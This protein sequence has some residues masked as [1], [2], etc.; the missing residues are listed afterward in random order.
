MTIRYDLESEKSFLLSLKLI[1]S[2][3]NVVWLVKISK[4]KLC[5]NFTRM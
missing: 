4:Y 3:K 2:R 5:R 1:K